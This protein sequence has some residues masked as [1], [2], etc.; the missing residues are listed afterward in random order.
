MSCPHRGRVWCWREL[1]RMWLMSGSAAHTALLR[2]L[3]LREAKPHPSQPKVGVECVADAT[4]RGS[5]A[6]TSGAIWTCIHFVSGA[7]SQRA[8][9]QYLVL[10]EGLC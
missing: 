10:R 2:L 7:A 8:V 1:L 5:I 9:I 4:Y 6:P 3:T